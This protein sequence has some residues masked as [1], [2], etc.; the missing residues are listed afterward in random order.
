[1]VL[2]GVLSGAIVITL[3]IWFTV[4]G[5]IYAAFGETGDI[6]GITYVVFLVL[7]A[8]LVARSG[9]LARKNESHHVRNHIE[10]ATA[11]SE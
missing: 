8:V 6:G 2:L 10:I 11:K 1:V 3:V 9:L 4:G 5:P 7:V